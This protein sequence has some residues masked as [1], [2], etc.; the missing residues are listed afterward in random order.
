MFNHNSLELHVRIGTPH[1]LTPLPAG[2]CVPTFGFGGDKLIS[3]R[4][5]E[6]GGSQFGREDR[7]LW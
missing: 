1:P 6:G 4:G 2:E 5:G 7:P 3:G